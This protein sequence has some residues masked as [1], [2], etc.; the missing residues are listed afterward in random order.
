MSSKTEQLIEAN[1]RGLL[2]GDKK[3]DF[4]EAV[5]R[6]LITLP[7]GTATSAET[8]AKPSAV[9]RSQEAQFHQPP[10]KEFS[11]LNTLKNIPSSAVENAGN[12]YQALR[13]PVQTGEAM[14]KTGLD[15]A[16][17]MD[18]T[19]SQDFINKNILGIGGEAEAM[20]DYAVDRYG[21]WDNIKNTIE[22]DP[23][24]FMLDASGAA[25]G[26]GSVLN[27]TG[28]AGKISNALRTTGKAIDP[29]NATVN[30]LRKGVS[31][32]IPKRLPESM[33]ESAVKFGTTVDERRKLVKTALKE[34]IMPTQAG[35]DKLNAKVKRLSGEIDTIITK[36]EDAGKRIP[37]KKVFT[38]IDDIKKELTGPENVYGTKNEK[39]INKIVD[40][41]KKQL[42]ADG[43]DDFSPTQVQ[44]L[45][46]NIYSDLDKAYKKN[47]KLR[48]TEGTLKGVAK[49]AREAV[50]ELDG[51]IAPRNAQA[52]DLLDLRDPLTRSANRIDNRD[53]I[54][55][56]PVAKAG[57]GGLVA[58]D[59]G[60]AAGTAAAVAGY[61]KNKAVLAIM[62]EQ[63]RKPEIGSLTKNRIAPMSL[64][65]ALAQS[66]RITLDD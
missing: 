49:G 45:K 30:T 1:S 14:V 66:G 12:I 35:L 61:P 43:V 28:K 55:I 23:V 39:V 65:Q 36:A 37:R 11:F 58:G 29:V 50:E 57:L 63:L 5:N 25:Y 15:V 53:F 20:K 38:H 13:H 48:P 56:D 8:P 6:G 10:P 26:T 34:K 21:G 41:Y 52:G 46:K 51:G 54:G 27:A 59:M 2:E 47:K 42:D 31:K 44:N 19:G 24:G 16:G 9:Q 33:Y 64:K 22:N 40:D 60:I 3:R 7:E 32:V 4:D 62:L 18:E 17:R